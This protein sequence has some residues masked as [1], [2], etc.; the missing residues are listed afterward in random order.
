MVKVSWRSCKTTSFCKHT[1]IFQSFLVAVTAGNF[2]LHVFG[3][4]NLLLNGE[5]P[6]VTLAS[7]G[8]LKLVGVAA[9][10]EGEFIDIAFKKLGGFR[11]KVC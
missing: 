6:A 1:K 8:C 11:L 9:S 4:I 10:L 2:F 7:S 5:E 3:F